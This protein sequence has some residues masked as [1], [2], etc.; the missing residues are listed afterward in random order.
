MT[1]KSS[2][3]GVVKTS[4]ENVLTAV[5]LATGPVILQMSFINLVDAPN[6][7]GKVAKMTI[8]AK[9]DVIIR[10]AVSVRVLW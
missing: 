6:C 4:V 2:N 5:M 1:S 10:M 9:S 7:V 8:S 3:L